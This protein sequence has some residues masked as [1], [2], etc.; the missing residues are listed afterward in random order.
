MPEARIRLTARKCVD[1][2]MGLCPNTFFHTP[3]PLRGTPSI[4][5]GELKMSGIQAPPLS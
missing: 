1:S 3:S 5:E 4:L 2:K